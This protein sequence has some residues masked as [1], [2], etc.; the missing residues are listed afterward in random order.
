MVHWRMNIKPN[1][2]MGDHQ[3]QLGFWVL[4]LRIIT[5][6]YFGQNFGIGC[7][8]KSHRRF[9]IFHK[10]LTLK[11][12]FKRLSNCHSFFFAFF[13]SR[14]YESVWQTFLGYSNC[15]KNVHSF[16]QS[17]LEKKKTK[18]NLSHQALKKRNPLLFGIS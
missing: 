6:W 4:L 13:V 18:P 10:I 7:S 11:V 3:S 15:T 14:Q 1:L 16:S 9:E 2:V 8:G 5:F 17:Y 12:L